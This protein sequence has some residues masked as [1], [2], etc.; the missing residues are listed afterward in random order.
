MTIQLAMQAAYATQLALNRPRSPIRET[1]SPAT[2]IPGT[3]ASALIPAVRATIS[4]PPP[5]S[6][7]RSGR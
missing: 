6:V 3:S 7:I 1:T 2:S 5:R 4:G